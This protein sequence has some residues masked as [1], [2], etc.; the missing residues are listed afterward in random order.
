MEGLK[1]SSGSENTLKQVLEEEKYKQQTRY[2]YNKVIFT[3]EANDRPTFSFTNGQKTIFTSLLLL[4]GLYFF[5]VGQPVLTLVTAAIFFVLFALV[6][7]PAQRAIHAVETLGIRSMDFLYGWE[8]LVSF[9]VAEKDGII[10]MYVDTRLKFPGRLVF[11]IESFQEAVSIV[12]LVIEKLPYR[13]LVE[14]QTALEK[15]FEGKYVIPDI[16]ISAAKDIEKKKNLV[17]KTK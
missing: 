7:F 4:L 10:I 8:D 11:L 9:W 17:N 2:E 12:N 6:S 3:W 15:N 1:T 13:A 5:W 14:P 16:F